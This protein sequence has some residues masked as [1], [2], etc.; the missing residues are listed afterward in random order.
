MHNPNPAPAA[1]PGLS[2]ARGAMSGPQTAMPMGARILSPRMGGAVPAQ[3]QDVFSGLSPG[4][5]AL[6]QPL[7]NIQTDPTSLRALTVKLDGLSPQIG[8]IWRNGVELMLAE[9]PG[10]R[11]TMQKLQSNF[12]L[13][14]LE[15]D[16]C[17]K[18]LGI[19]RVDISVHDPG[20]RRNRTLAVAALGLYAKAQALAILAIERSDQKLHRSCTQKLRD[21]MAKGNVHAQLVLNLMKGARPMGVR[22]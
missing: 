2:A 17:V 1:A 22:L 15:I 3:Q 9:P 8:Q 16:L 14:P 12:G 10:P 19:R 7:D 13:K 20:L 4:S 21:D 6:L 11:D 18:M 5:E